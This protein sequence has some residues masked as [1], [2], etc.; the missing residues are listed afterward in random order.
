VGKDKPKWVGSS[1]G[2][3]TKNENTQCLGCDVTEFAAMYLRCPCIGVSASGF[4]MFN[5]KTP[6]AFLCIPLRVEQHGT[7]EIVFASDEVG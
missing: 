7:Y 6:E 1:S 3:L 5:P 4:F 2:S